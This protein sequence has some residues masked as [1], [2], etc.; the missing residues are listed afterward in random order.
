MAQQDDIQVYSKRR[1]MHGIIAFTFLMYIARL[2]Q[3]Q[4]I[5]SEEYGRKSEENSVRTVPREPV[6]GTIFD[7]NGTLVVDNRPAFT[8][9]IIPFE[10][11][12]EEHRVP[13]LPALARS[14]GRPGPD[15]KG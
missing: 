8:V 14:R 7:K 2:Y 6:R 11:D 4:L 1:V 3:L 5:Y 12:K 9:C 15:K 10:F 13:F